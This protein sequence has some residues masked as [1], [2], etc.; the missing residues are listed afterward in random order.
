CSHS[1]TGPGRS[2]PRRHKGR[3]V[4][5]DAWY[6]SLSFDLEISAPWA[7]WRGRLARLA[8]GS[9]THTGQPPENR[10]Y[11]RPRQA[12]TLTD[13]G[14]TS[15][16]CKLPYNRCQG[17]IRQLPKWPDFG[18]FGF[19]ACHG[20]RDFGR[21]PGHALAATHSAHAQAPPAPARPADFG[22]DAGRLARRRGSS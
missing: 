5:T 4:P 14:H 16:T 9:M 21:R 19:G 8:S 1:P 7:R 13:F 18:D 12:W 20:C 2:N 6:P 17:K 11:H 3:K 10:Q 22:L 15:K